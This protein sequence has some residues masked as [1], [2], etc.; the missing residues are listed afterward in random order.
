[1]EQV[2]GRRVGFIPIDY[3]QHPDVGPV[4]IA[5]LTA[6]AVHADRSG[7]CWPSQATIAALTKLDRSTVNRVIGRLVGMGFVEKSPSPHHRTMIYRLIGHD[8]LFERQ[9]DLTDNTCDD[10]VVSSHTEHSTPNTTL[11]TN[12]EIVIHKK[13]ELSPDWTPSSSDISFASVHRPDIPPSYLSKIRDKFVERY[14]GTLIS[15]PSSVFRRWVLSE[16]VPTQTIKRNSRRI[17]ECIFPSDTTKVPSIYK[18]I[19]SV[20]E[21]QNWIRPCDIS[22]DCGIL[23]LSAPT[24][25]AR[26]WIDTHYRVA[27]MRA[28]RV[29]SIELMVANATN[30]TENSRL[31]TTVAIDKNRILQ[32]N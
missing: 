10:V 16:R 5:V 32:P 9:T 31:L 11:P 3:L 14:C 25:L 12:S 4:E 21:W 8:H 15:E 29:D 28:H 26:D 19:I 17:S 24:K 30:G 1:M 18:S 23:R 13:T 7:I 2:S 20:A 27:L 22:V 6:L